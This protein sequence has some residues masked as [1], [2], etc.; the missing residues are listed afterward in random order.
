MQ[1][2]K[3]KNILKYLGKVTIVT[4]LIVFLIHTFLFELHT[5]SSSQMESSLSQGD[6]VLIS[7]VSYGSRLPITLLSIPFTGGSCYSDLIKLPYMRLISADVLR[8]DVVVFNSP[9]ETDKPLDKRSLLVSR[10]V[11]IPGDTVLIADGVYRI[12]GS[13]YVHAPTQIEKYFTFRDKINTLQE[14]AKNLRIEL[15]DVSADGDTIY[16]VASKYDAFILRENVGKDFFYRIDNKEVDRVVFIMPSKDRK[17]LLTENNVRLYRPIIEL[18]QGDKV[19]FKNNQVYIDD[20]LLD[21]YTF[22]DDY[23]WML[24]D[25]TIDALDS[26]S[27]GFI[28]FR[29]VVGRAALILYSSENG[30]VKSNRFFKTVR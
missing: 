20:Q 29:N 21:V 26:R 7:K 19:S 22:Q 16:F 2:A 15:R 28:P 25:N 10:C 12:N 24:S 8:N 6:R 1:K 17:V 5:I 3:N 11:A 23:Y 30:R 13:Q 27:L 14:T 4:L 9:Q 18:E